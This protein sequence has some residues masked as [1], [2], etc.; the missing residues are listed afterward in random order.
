MREVDRVGN[1]IRVRGID[2]DEL[3][4]LAHLDLAANLQILAET[5]LFADSRLPNHLNKGTSA[6]VEDGQFE[7]V[8]LDDRVINA[9]A[10]EG[11]KHVLGGRD[12]HA[13]LHKARGI[14]YAG[15][16]PADRLDFETIQIG[17]AKH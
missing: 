8:Q 9:H 15:D 11:G 4:P 6:A 10:D 5:P 3:V 14:T 7:V 13:F 17:A 12:E 2:R 1:R 16:I